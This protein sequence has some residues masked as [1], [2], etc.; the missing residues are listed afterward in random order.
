MDLLVF[1]DQNSPRVEYVFEHVFNY[2]YGLDLLF[3]S[4]RNYFIKSK[5]PKISY[6]NSPVS[7]TIFFQSSDLLFDSIITKQEL[8]ISTTLG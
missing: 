3:T 8:K 5:N 1:L 4:D 2:F 6:S 7:N